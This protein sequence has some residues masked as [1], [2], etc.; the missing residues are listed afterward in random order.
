[1]SWISE[2][3]KFI[4]RF[5]VEK[6][7]TILFYKECYFQHKKEQVEFQNIYFWKVCALIRKPDTIYI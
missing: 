6:F 1:M 7:N 3:K 2:F 5:H 4:Q